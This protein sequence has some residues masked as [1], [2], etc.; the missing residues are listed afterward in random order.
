[1]WRVC[2]TLDHMVISS[3]DMLIKKYIVIKRRS[4]SS[5]HETVYANDRK[6]NCRNNLHKL[7]GK[8]PGTIMK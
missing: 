6:T 1:M 4:R 8:T 3:I 2:K 5:K 7:H